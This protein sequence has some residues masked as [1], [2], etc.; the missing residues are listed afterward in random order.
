VWAR[1]RVLW[2]R[3]AG[4]HVVVWQRLRVKGW[5]PAILGRAIACVARQK[6]TPK[7]PEV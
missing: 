6:C 4:G 2:S 5:G 1:A 7:A 3:W